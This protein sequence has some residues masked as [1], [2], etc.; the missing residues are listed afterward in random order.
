MRRLLIAT[1]LALCL[2]FGLAAQAHAAAFELSVMQDDNQL[3][4]SSAANR[5][6]ALE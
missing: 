3:I 6:V 4:Y 2:T 5:I 1:A